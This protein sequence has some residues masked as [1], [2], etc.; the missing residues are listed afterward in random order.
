MAFKLNNLKKISLFTIHNSMQ[1]L[2]VTSSGMPV[3]VFLRLLLEGRTHL[4]NFNKA[5]DCTY[6]FSNDHL[7]P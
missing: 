7:K 3:S 4:H 5:I 1:T 2:P 6:C